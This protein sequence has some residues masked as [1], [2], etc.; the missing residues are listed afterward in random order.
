MKDEKTVTLGDPI[1]HETKEVRLVLIDRF[2]ISKA[3][4]KVKKWLL[5]IITGE[6]NFIRRNIFHVTNSFP[7]RKPF[8]PENFPR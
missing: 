1:T 6:N 3:I 2:M 8:P 5:S 4:K 7:L